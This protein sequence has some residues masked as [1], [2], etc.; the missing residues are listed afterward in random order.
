MG[1]CVKCGSAAIAVKWIGGDG[2]TICISKQQVDR[3]EFV[4]SVARTFDYKVISIKEH[5]C[6]SCDCCGYVWREST[7]DSELKGEPIPP[8]LRRFKGVG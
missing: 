6:K 5:L 3:T 1:S 7:K 8:P 2:Q 4:T